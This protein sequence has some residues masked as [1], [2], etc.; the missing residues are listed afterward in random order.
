MGTPTEE[1]IARLMLI[2]LALFALSVS[3]ARPDMK[4]G[5]IEWQR[6][7]RFSDSDRREIV[8]AATRAGLTDIRKVSRRWHRPSTDRYHVL[9]ES[10]RTITGRRVTWRALIVCGDIDRRHCEDERGARP[11]V[12]AGRWITS[13]S[14][15]NEERLRVVDGNWQRDVALGDGV[16]EEVADLIVLAVHRRTL[17]NRTPNQTRY[18]DVLVNGYAD[19]PDWYSLHITRVPEGRDRYQLLFVADGAIITLELRVTG[20]RVEVSGTSHIDA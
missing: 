5:R 1:P 16:S 18:G 11:V 17:I 9:V 20:E 3:C 19:L 12:S 2:A 13:S 8:D 4:V 10:T 6:D 7:D 14:V 15:F